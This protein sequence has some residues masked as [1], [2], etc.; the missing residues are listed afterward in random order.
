MHYAWRIGVSKDITP[1][2]AQIK[3]QKEGIPINWIHRF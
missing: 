3:T 1:Q 2:Q